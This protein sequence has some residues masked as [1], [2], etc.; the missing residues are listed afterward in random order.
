MNRIIRYAV[1]QADGMV[2]S[3]VG[4]EFAW[5]ILDW[6]AMKPENNFATS[7]YLERVPVL[8]IGSEYRN[9]KFTRKIPIQIKNAHRAFW[10]MKEVQS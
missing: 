9:L 7:Y 4:D 5:P 3:R 6:D 2:V 1:N 10:G 8:S